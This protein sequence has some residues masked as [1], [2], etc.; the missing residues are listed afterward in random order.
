MARI[1]LDQEAMGYSLVMEQLTHVHVKDCFREEDMVYFVVATGELGRAVGKGGVVIKRVQ[2]QLGKKVRVI[3]YRDN[4]VDFVKNVIYPLTAQEVI[5][6]ESKIIIRDG[7]TKTKSLLIGRNARNL[8][9]INKAVHRF[10]DKEVTVEFDLAGEHLEEEE[11]T[12]RVTVEGTAK[13]DHTGHET[14]FTQEVEVKREN[15]K[16]ILQ[17]AEVSP[18]LLECTSQATLSVT[19]ENIGKSDEEKVEVRLSNTALGLNLNQADIEV[20]SFDRSDN[21]YRTS[22][23]LS[24]PNAAAGVYPLT[25][26]LY[27]E[28]DLVDSKEVILAVGSCAAAETTTVTQTTATFEVTDYSSPQVLQK[29]S[30]QEIF[31]RVSASF[32]D[33]QQYLLLLGGIVVLLALAVILASAVLVKRR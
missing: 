4:P 30:Q 24:L 29:A 20:D 19:V 8:Q 22:F 1:K 11:Y 25:V 18:T 31:K 26:N 23:S 7:S 2:E 33:S 28:E 9:F 15:H 12:V 17:R 5:E 10:F 21:E 16:V 14:E 6:E 13:D 32:R 3:E 27:S